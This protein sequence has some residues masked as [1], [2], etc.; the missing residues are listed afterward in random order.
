MRLSICLILASVMLMSG[1][2][3]SPKE[4]LEETR[5]DLTDAWMILPN[6]DYDGRVLRLAAIR[7]LRDF[8]ADHPEHPKYEAPDLRIAEPWRDD[9]TDG[10]LLQTWHMLAYPAVPVLGRDFSRR[11]TISVRPDGERHWRI[12]ILVERFERLKSPQ[13]KVTEG[14]HPV[15]PDMVSA[16]EIKNFIDEQL[17]KMEKNKRLGIAETDF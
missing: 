2:V 11:I 1:C 4:P 17:Q 14:W 10:V 13:Q 6:L 7:A 12:N 8:F 15:E 16:I 9:N 3:T 5:V